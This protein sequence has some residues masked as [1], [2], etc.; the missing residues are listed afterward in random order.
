MALTRKCDRCGAFYDRY[1][2]NDSYSIENS[3]A[4]AFIIRYKNDTYNT[5]KRFDLCPDCKDELVNWILEGGN[6]S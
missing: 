2:E 4:I 1:N 3:N 6:E 5:C